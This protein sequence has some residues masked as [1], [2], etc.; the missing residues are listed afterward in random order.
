V[1]AIEFDDRKFM[2]DMLNVIGYSE[3]FASG[4]EAGTSELLQAFGLH[5]VEAANEYIDSTSRVNPAKLEH[6][7]EWAMNGSP[8]GRLFDIDKIVNGN[9]LSV[10]ASFKQSVTVKEGSKE[11]FY[12][13]ANIM[14]KGLPVKVEPKESSVLK[15]DIDGQTVF[16]KKPVTIKDPGGEQAQNGFEETFN[17]FFNMFFSQSF[18]K[19]GKLSQYLA[20]PQAYHKN[21]SSARSGGKSLGK[22][23]GR[24]WMKDAGE[25]A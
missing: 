4:A 22:S 10:K 6:V 15:F 8:S 21:F 2:K 14:E 11:P 7:Y 9:T 3:G 19:S 18:L 1:F 5:A 12:N 20:S 17:Q 13:K 23:V 25:V 16:T 24:K